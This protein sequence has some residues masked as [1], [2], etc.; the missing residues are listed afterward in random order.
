MQLVLQRPGETIHEFIGRLMAAARRDQARGTFNGVELD[1][2]RSSTLGILLVKYDEE[3]AEIERTTRMT[4]LESTVRIG[5]DM[6]A[7]QT[8]YFKD[9]SRDNLIASKQ[10]ESA[11]DT[12]AREAL[13]DAV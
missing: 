13:R 3:R 6:R 4:K 10:A 1:A 12:A 11:F 9:R 5:V 2:D 7:K 8:A